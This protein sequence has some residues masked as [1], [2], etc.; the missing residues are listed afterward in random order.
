MTAVYLLLTEFAKTSNTQDKLLPM[1]QSRTGKGL[2][3][4]QVHLQE[5]KGPRML[6]AFTCQT[7]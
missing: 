6:N 7:D 2:Q 3:S 1:L 4:W 5:N